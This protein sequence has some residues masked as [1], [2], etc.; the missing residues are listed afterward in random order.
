MYSQFQFEMV[1]PL[2][3]TIGG[4]HTLTAVAATDFVAFPPLSPHAEIYTT[5]ATA[6]PSRS[7]GLDYQDVLGTTFYLQKSF[8]ACKC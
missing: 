3:R 2:I 6:A 4:A 5:R 7:I 8:Q 1:S